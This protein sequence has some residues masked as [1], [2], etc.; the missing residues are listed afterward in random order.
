MP[1]QFKGAMHLKAFVMAI[2]VL[3]LAFIAVAALHLFFGLN[4]DAMLGS[5]VT[6]DMVSQ[7]S[8]D[9][10]NRFYG[11]TFSMLGVVLLI[12]SRDLRRYEPMIIATLGVL[13]MAGISRVVAWIIHGAP[14]SMLIGILFA[15][16]ILPPVLYFWFKRIA[17]P[18]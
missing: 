5:P 16:L 10:Q 3:A 14:S 15:D 13:F 8:F 12:S 18:I 6:A 2:R 1:Q 11:I 17:R 4:A 9:S 7:P